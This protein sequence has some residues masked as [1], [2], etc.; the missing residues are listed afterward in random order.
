MKRF[1]IKF[2]KYIYIL[3]LRMRL[4]NKGV[5]ILSN[6][7]TAGIIYHK[8]KLRFMSPTINLQI[9]NMDFLEFVQHLREYE[10]CELIEDVSTQEAYPVGILSDGQLKPVTIHF[11]HYK[12]FEEAKEK[13][14]ERYKRINYS[15]LCIVMEGGN[16]TTDEL[17]ETFHNLPFDK[18][19][20]FVNEYI[21]DKSYPEEFF[22]DIYSRDYVPGKLIYKDEERGI[23]QYIY[24]DRFDYVAFL[25]SG[26][27]KG[28]Q[29]VRKQKRRQ[30]I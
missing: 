30:R 4:T 22:V 5:T 20:L 23:G 29:Y 21:A 27:I 14:V 19:V 13:W 11:M 10:H 12:S 9:G 1:M 3:L 8:L 17:K 26:V 16:F 18:K 7:C 2:Y 28:S 6:N 25:N 15:N 24:L